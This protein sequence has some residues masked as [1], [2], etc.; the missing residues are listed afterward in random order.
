MSEQRGGF[1]SRTPQAEQQTRP[2]RRRRPARSTPRVRVDLPRQTAFSALRAVFV[3]GAYGNIAVN[4]ALR[5][6]GLNGRNAAFT[7]EISYGVMRTVGVLDEIIADCSSRPIDELDDAVLIALRMGIYEILYMRVEDH[8]AVSTT[9][10]LVG[11]NVAHASDG[12]KGFVNAV[13]RTVTRSTKDEWIAKLS[14]EGEIAAMAFATAHPEWIAESF[15]RILGVDGAR[16]ELIADS[17]RPR[18]HLAARPGEITAEELALS[19]GGEE[20]KYSPYAVYLTKGNPAKVEAVQE[21]LAFVEDEGSQLVGRSLTVAGVEGTDHGNWLDLCAGPG[22]KTQFIGAIAATEQAHV[23]AVEVVPHRADLVRQAVEGLPVT[24]LTADGRTV[25]NRPEVAAVVDEFG[26]FDRVLVDAPCSGLGALRRHQEARWIKSEE[27]ITGLN[28][29][30]Q[31]L[32]QAAVELTRPGG[33]VIYATCSPD[34]RET[35]AIVDWGVENLPVTELD[36]HPLVAPMENVGE[37]KSVQMW[38][39]LHGTDCMFFACL[40]VNE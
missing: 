34:L 14:P 32:L 13:L 3:D 18:V 10:E 1:R 2:P 7:T 27:D 36:A 38:T 26:G 9:V 39:H 6:S 37:D 40:R 4:Q 33:V 20:G 19:C 12:V 16:E 24:T 15:V 22:G 17:Q 8:A 29:L 5:K 30:Q 25:K 28:G 31:E 35:R 11:A 23:T 21:R